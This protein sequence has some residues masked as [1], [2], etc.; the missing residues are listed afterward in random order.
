MIQKSSNVP[1][2]LILGGGFGG[3]ACANRLAKSGVKITLVDRNN[4]HLF[5]PLLYQV[6]TAGLSQTEIA[7]PIR[8]NLSGQKNTTVIMDEV[9]GIDLKEKKI[10]LKYNTLTYDYLIIALGGVTSYFGN[11]HWGKHA[12]GLK[13]LNDATSIRKNVLYAYEKAEMTADES[14]HKRLMTSVVVGGGPTGVEMAGALMELA[15]HVLAKD[16]QHVDVKESKVILIEASPKILGT[17]PDPLPEKAKQALENLGVEVKTNCPVKDIQEK[18]VFLEKETLEAENIIWAAGVQAPKLTQELGVK[19][20]RGGRI[21]VEPDCS[22]PEF[23]DVFAIGDIV[24]LTDAEG[25]RVPG[26]SPGAIQMGQFVADI[27]STE[28]SKAPQTKRKS[29]VYFD[30]GSM[31]TIG[32]SKAIA[33]IGPLKFSG[34]LAW[35]LW[36]LVHLLFLIGFRNRVMVLVQWFYS[37]VQYQRGARIITNLHQPQEAFSANH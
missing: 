22:L 28:I 26:V 1:H 24:T 8:S 6:A 25:Q 31:A 3:L 37:Y 30:K 2:V 15:H 34:L 35:L 33:A 11:D 29:F 4:Y 17:F 32:R 27:I 21:L 19:L 9:I 20:D 23:P 36:L 10:E 5:Q 16:F 12:I 14:M 7:K 13:S 18:K